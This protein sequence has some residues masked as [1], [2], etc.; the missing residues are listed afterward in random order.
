MNQAPL[1]PL[2]FEPIYQYRLWGGRR[3]AD[4]LI[5]P[6]PSGPAGEAWILSDRD[7]HPSQVADGPLKGRTIGQLL[8]HSPEQLLGKFIGR[9]RR[10]PLLLKFLD[11][12]EMLSVQVHPSDANKSLLPPGETGK[13]EAWVVLEAGT[14]SRIYAGLKPGT[15]PD[16]LRRALAN[17]TAVDRLVCFTPKPGDGVFMPAGTVHAL[18]GDVVAFE[19]QQN[20]DVTFSLYDWDHVDAKTGHPRALQIEQALSCINF[21]EGDAAGLVTPVAEATTPAERERLFHCEH[22]WLWRLRGESSFAV[23]AANVPRVLVCIEGAGQVEHG[24]AT[25]A[26]AKGDVLLLPAVVGVCAFQPSSA[27]NL[28]E[29]GIPEIATI[30]RAEE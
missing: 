17:E 4:L 1:Y 8:E 15:T 23:G 5:A 27:V 21:A 28:L 30:Q 10:F 16:V 29:I 20:S 22:F 2:R 14:E 24:G 6:L 19:I 9:F 7:D 18:G 25:Y 12:H 3:L 11:A 13:T 26:V